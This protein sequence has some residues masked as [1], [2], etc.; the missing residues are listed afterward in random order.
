MASSSSCDPTHLYNLWIKA[1]WTILGWCTAAAAAAGGAGIAMELAL[2]GFELLLFAWESAGGE[3]LPM[4]PL[5]SVSGLLLG[6][7]VADVLAAVG[8][9]TSIGSPGDGADIS[10]LG[11]GMGTMRAFIWS[12]GPEVERTFRC[13]L[14]V[15][16]AILW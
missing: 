5:I 11:V 10:I 2:F 14:S 4:E 12:S 9:V 13:G 6:V 8:V 1:V 3:P 7:M 15:A 16:A